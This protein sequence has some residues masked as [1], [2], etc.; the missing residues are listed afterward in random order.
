VRPSALFPE[1]PVVDFRAPHRDCVCGGRLKTQKTQTKRV[2]SLSGTYIARRIV[3]RCAGCGRLWHDPTLRRWVAH[4]CNTAWDVLIFVGRRLFEDC[5]SVGQVCAELAARDVL[6]SESQITKLGRKFILCLALAHRRATPRIKLAMAQRGGYILHLD[7]LHQEDAPAL[8]SGIDGLSR[9]VLANVK[10]PSEHATQIIPFLEKI[11]DHYGD[12]IACVHDMGTGICKAVGEV[13][14]AS[15][16]YVCHFHFLRDAGKDLIEPAYARLRGC[17]RRHGFQSR[18]SAQA[19]HARRLL[20]DERDRADKG[21][22]VKSGPGLTPTTAAAV[23][24]LSLWCLQAK[25]CG[26]G[27]GFPFDRPL[28]AMAE[29]VMILL[30]CLPRLMQTLGGANLAANRLFVHLARQVMDVIADPDFETNVEELRWR[31]LLFDQLRQAMRIAVAGGRQ[32]LND[33]GT[34]LEMDTIRKR[35]DGFRHRLD[36]EA[37]LATDPL[38]CK[39]AAQIDKYHEKLFADPILVST[40]SGPVRVYP[41]RTNNIL[42]QFFRCLRRDHRRRTGDNRMHRALQTMLADTPLVKNLSNPEY[43]KI[44]LDGRPN[45]EAL[46]ADL[47]QSGATDPLATDSDAD[48]ILPAFRALTKMVDLPYRMSEIASAEALEVKSNQIVCS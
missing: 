16:D 18:L 20:L 35:V 47:D 42:E 3:L 32:G 37:K 28:L 22:A 9:L 45:L 13:F 40:P 26:D 38:C 43:M 30:D 11:K 25:H 6:L 41:Q 1:P 23:Y 7:A 46:F 34:G 5:R 15:K 19:R 44:L 39:L 2:V 36:A 8:M 12:P 33:D 21:A 31:C 48:R 14:P 24:A 17:L 29:R 27:Y 10:V 4:G